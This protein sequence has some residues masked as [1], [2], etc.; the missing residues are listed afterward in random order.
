MILTTACG[1]RD[2]KVIE[3]KLSD[4]SE[5]ME[6]LEE[7]YLKELE[8]SPKEETYIKLA[9]LYRDE[10]RY[11]DEYDILMAARD[12]IEDSRD[13]DIRYIQYKS[14]IG[15]RNEAER[16]INMKLEE[17]FDERLVGEMFKL[18]L[19][20]WNI[21]N[22]NSYYVDS[23][24]KIE[25]T[26]TKVLAY[27]A[28]NDDKLYKEELKTKLLDSGELAVLQ[29]VLDEEISN[30]NYEEV[31][32][33]LPSL[34][35]VNNGQNIYNIYSKLVDLKDKYVEDYEIGN[36]INKNK[37]DLVI[38]YRKDYK[39][40]D[41]HI[42][43]MDGSTG[44]VVIDKSMGEYQPEFIDLDIFKEKDKLDQL[45]V[46][47][48][49]GASATSGKGFHFCNFHDAG[50]EMKPIELEDDVEV[51][52]L[53]DFKIQ[54]ESKKLKIK[55]IIEIP[56]EDRMAY[57]EDNQFNKDGKVIEEARPWEYNDGFF[58]R[59]RGLY[60]DTIGQILGF[61][62]SF[63][64]NT[65]RL[66][67]AYKLYNM[68]DGKLV[69]THFNINDISNMNKNLAYEDDMLI[70]NFSI[71]DEEEDLRQ[72]ENSLYGEY[73]V[74]DDFKVDL[75]H[76]VVS[77]TNAKYILDNI[78]PGEVE[79]L[80]KVN[81]KA[82]RYRHRSDGIIM[83]YVEKENDVGKEY[84]CEVFLVDKPGIKTLRG[85]EVGIDEKELM[86]LYPRPEILEWPNAQTLYVYREDMRLGKTEY[87]LHMEL[88]VIVDNN[89]KK[90]VEYYYE[91]IL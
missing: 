76:K 80:E 69:N 67:S 73:L 10:Y 63:A 90:V 19:K 35:K 20:H 22:I 53:E 15:D 57:I 28:I 83:D 34:K 87:P 1:E 79:L 36:F 54:V 82:S 59:D 61:G 64:Y 16:L 55:Y 58:V 39:D 49:S 5:D 18:Q 41:R 45:L 6:S 88:C 17:E 72:G 33:L 75:G 48:Y 85:L 24:D 91:F 2:P 68:I 71:E 3:A 7:K 74:E 25:K 78:G 52:L 13:A 12:K 51:T 43:L 38:I 70:I 21:D 14:L 66:A 46:K 32:R 77:M 86:D 31:A 44:E 81:E 4:E 50:Y 11:N 84:Y 89:T 37:K 40:R 9:D 27:K 26:E 47:T 42:F 30:N 8:K 29:V 60:R 23:V 56:K 62:G 65:D